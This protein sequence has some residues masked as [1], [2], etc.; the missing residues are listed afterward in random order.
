MS[1]DIALKYSLQF[2]GGYVNDPADKGGATNKGITKAVY[3]EYR[4]KN[5]L[6]IQ[7]VKNISDKEVRDIYYKQYWLASGCDKLSDK[8]AIVV[9]D[10]AINSGV[11][12]AKRY[13]TLTQDPN[14]Y[15]DLRAG[16]FKKIVQNNPSQ[17]KFLKGWLNRVE[18]L[19]KII[20]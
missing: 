9:F 7:S 10:M 20:A 17:Q 15:L 2:E 4:T 1:F 18:N 6:P 3:D 16:F 8:L 14:K 11:S 5:S 12:R 19:R 13:L